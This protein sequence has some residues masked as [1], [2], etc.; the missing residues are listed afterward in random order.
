[1]ATFYYQLLQKV[2]FLFNGIPETVGCPAVSGIPFIFK[3]GLVPASYHNYFYENA[4][5]I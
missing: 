3:A 4:D 5:L 2:I 1:M